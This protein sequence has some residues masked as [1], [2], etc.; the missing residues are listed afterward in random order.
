MKEKIMEEAIQESLESLKYNDI[1]VGAI[2][3][4]NDQIIAQAHNS[5][6]KNNCI[7]SHAEIEVINQAIK[8]IGDNYLDDCELYITMEPCLMCF[9]AISK[10]NIKKIYYAVPNEK[11]GF[12]NFLNYMPKLEIESGICKEKVK[13]ILNEFFKNKRN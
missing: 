13:N 6:K 12:S 11:Y 3:V 7:H 2:I 9:G 4:K 5:C 10:T 1:P 8:I